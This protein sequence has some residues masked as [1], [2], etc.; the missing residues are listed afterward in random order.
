MNIF[1]TDGDSFYPY[2]AKKQKNTSK[3]H[4]MLMIRY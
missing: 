2:L 3:E 1:M 4:L